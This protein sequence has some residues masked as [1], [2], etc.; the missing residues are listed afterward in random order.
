MLEA[1]N[2]PEAE[3]SD[4]YQEMQAAAARVRARG[5]LVLENAA[6]A[7]SGAEENLT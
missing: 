2:G 1:C 6:D 3:T 5:A 7:P 4:L